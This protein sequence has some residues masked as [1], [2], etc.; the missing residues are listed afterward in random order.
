M[1][2]VRPPAFK[3]GQVSVSTPCAVVEVR[4]A[5]GDRVEVGSAVLVTEAMKM[6]TEA[7]APISGVVSQ[8]YVAKGDRVV[9]GEALV[10]IEA[11]AS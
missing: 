1:E 9:P 5:V 6:E 3:P 11:E 4:V 10:E 8:V 7:H 2:G